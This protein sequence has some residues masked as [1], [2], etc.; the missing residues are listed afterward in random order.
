MGQSAASHDED[1]ARIIGRLDYEGD[2]TTQKTLLAALLRLPE[3]VR[4]FA[5]D[6]CSFIALTDAAG[7]NS[8]KPPDR[9][10]VVLQAGI[11]DHG[12]KRAIAEAWLSQDAEDTTED[13][14]VEVDELV[15]DWEFTGPGADA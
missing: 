9:H 12:V 1:T 2:D 4:T 13:D 10:H 7:K 11:G 6:R 15:A 3:G 8:T 14:R 5:L